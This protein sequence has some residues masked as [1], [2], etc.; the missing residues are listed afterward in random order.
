MNETNKEMTMKKYM[1]PNVEVM[2]VEIESLLDMT[3]VTGLDDVTTGEGEFPGGNA[4]SRE[5]DIFFDDED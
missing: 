4:D 5:L 1:K 3:S 2:D